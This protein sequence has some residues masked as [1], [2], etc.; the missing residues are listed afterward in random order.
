MKTDFCFVIIRGRQQ[1][2]RQLS[3]ADIGRIT[4]ILRQQAR[5]YE[6]LLEMAKYDPVL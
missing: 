2:K 4:K 5:E 1:Q 3:D 6:A